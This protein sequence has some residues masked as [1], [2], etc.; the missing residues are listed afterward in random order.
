MAASGSPDAGGYRQGGSWSLQGTGPPH[1]RCPS[2]GQQIPAGWQDGASGSAHRSGSEGLEGVS[3]R[4]GAGQDG[5]GHSSQ[6]S[7]LVARG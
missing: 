3:K 6:D 1:G 7:K 2:T 5:T 4:G